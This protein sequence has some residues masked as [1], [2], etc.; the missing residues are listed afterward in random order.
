MVDASRISQARQTARSEAAAMGIT[1]EQISDLVETFYGHVREDA[2][3]GPVFADA[4][5]GDWEPHLAT[6]KRFW[7]ALVFHD[8][9]YQGRPMPANVKLKPQI[10]PAHFER[11]LALFGQT[12][13]EIGATP[14][15]KTALLERANRI[16]ASFQAH[17]FHDPYENA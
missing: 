4:I 1:P 17:L 15:A 12:L 10:S 14:A 16:A 3:L 7:S 8:G 9:G 5:A 13:D 11:W 2:M 6:M